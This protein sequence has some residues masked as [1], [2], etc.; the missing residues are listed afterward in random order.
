MKRWIDGH[1]DADPAIQRHMPASKSGVVD[2]I[3]YVQARGIRQ[4]RLGHEVPHPDR[5]GE[6]LRIR[7]SLQQ[8]R[9][10]T[11]AAA[12]LGYPY[13]FAR[14]HKT[15]LFH[16]DIVFDLGDDILITL[17]G[18]SR[19]QLLFPPIVERYLFHLDFGPDGL[20]VKDIPLRFEDRWIEIDPSIKYGTPRVMP[21][22][23]AV[24]AL[25]NAVIDEGGIEEA[26]RAYGVDAED[27]RKAYEYED[28][29]SGIAA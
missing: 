2:F 29:L 27:V 7:P 12:E 17:T 4:L 13:P 16:N 21:C 1:G 22:G 26:A 24:S 14:D 5:M 25:S 10:A 23:V 18:K 28:Y 20:A 3:D 6:T 19:Q 15:Y 8:I 9:Q 11:Q